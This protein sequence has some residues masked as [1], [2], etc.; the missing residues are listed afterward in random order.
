MWRPWQHPPPKAKVSPEKQ[1]I[2]CI[3]I[4]RATH[5]KMVG[6]CYP[7]KKKT[8]H[9]PDAKDFKCPSQKQRYIPSLQFLLHATNLSTIAAKRQEHK[10]NFC[11]CLLVLFPPCLG[12][13]L[14]KSP[15]LYQLLWR[16]NF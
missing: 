14:P 7:K 15:P 11:S 3:A 5:D 6:L 2:T 8:V 12:G 1:P 9:N 10:H 13:E 4:R 16:I